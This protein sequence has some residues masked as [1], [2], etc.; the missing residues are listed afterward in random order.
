[1]QE[2][3]WNRFGN[4]LRLWGVVLGANLLGCLASAW[5][6]SCGASFDDNVR[7]EFSDIGRLAMD[8]S[9]LMHIMRGIFAGWLIAL[10]IWVLPFAE[11][12]GF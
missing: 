7:H 6:A 1:M 5:A 4:V 2:K 9:F 8:G 3:T 10:M 11:G 12:A